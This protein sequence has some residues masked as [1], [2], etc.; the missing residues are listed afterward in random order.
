[1]AKFTKTEELF[2]Y[3]Q[4]IG[5]S[6][7]PVNVGNPL[8]IY[9]GGTRT[10]GVFYPERGQNIEFRNPLHSSWTYMPRSHT[11]FSRQDFYQEVQCN[12]NDVLIFP[13]WLSHRVQANKTKENRVVMSMNIVG[14]KHG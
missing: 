6:V 10:L 4:Q 5:Q 13:A 2:N 7:G 9:D 14:V 1:M 12:T 8:S 3:V 11:E